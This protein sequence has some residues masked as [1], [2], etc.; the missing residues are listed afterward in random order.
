MYQVR[1]TRMPLA[2]PRTSSAVDLVPPAMMMLPGSPNARLPCFCAQKRVYCRLAT[3]PS[4]TI[5]VRSRGRPSS[6]HGMTTACGCAGSAV[7]VT[8]GSK[9]C[10]PTRL[11]PPFFDRKLR[12][13]SASRAR[14]SLNMKASSPAAAAGSRMTVYL[15]GSSALASADA[16][17]LRI[18]V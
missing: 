11:P 5:G 17:A 14:K 16:L 10:S 7:K 1:V 8:R 3:L 4:V 9:T 12:P 6:S 2:V 15:P 18:A 13:S